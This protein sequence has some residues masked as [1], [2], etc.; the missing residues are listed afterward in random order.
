MAAEI[1]NLKSW[2]KSAARAEARVRADGNAARFGRSKALKKL[3]EARA[4]KSRSDLDGHL[5]HD[6]GAAPG[7]DDEIPEGRG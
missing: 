3:E 7:S 4:G 5:R 6:P 1:I 2:R